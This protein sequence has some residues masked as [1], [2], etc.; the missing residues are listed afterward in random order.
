MS[1]HDIWMQEFNER[2]TKSGIA[3]A[4]AWNAKRE[5]PKPEIYP[6]QHV[7]MRLALQPWRARICEICGQFFVKD[8]PRDRY[9]SSACTTKARLASK[10]SYWDSN[11]S[12]LRPS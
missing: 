10:R 3:E 8:F 9:C 1:E 6:Y 5:I 4:M 7:I 2:M 11:K 12:K